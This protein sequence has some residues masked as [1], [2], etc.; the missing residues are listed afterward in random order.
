MDKLAD[1]LQKL[2]S[3]VKGRQESVITQKSADWSVIQHEHPDIAGFITDFS[4][5]FGKPGMVIVKDQAGDVLLD[6]RRYE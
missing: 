1:G 6:T 2:A 5:V 4:I 3:K